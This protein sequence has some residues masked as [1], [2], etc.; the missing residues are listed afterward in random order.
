MRNKSSR[1]RRQARTIP[2]KGSDE[3]GNG[4]DA[5]VW[6]RCWNCGFICSTDRDS[7]GGPESGSGVIVQ[8]FAVPVHGAET[9]IPNSGIARLGGVLSQ[10]TLA[11]G[12]DDLG[13]TQPIEEHHMPVVSGGCPFCGTLD[14][15]GDYP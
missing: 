14:W 3:R 15:K 7:L 9:G 12:V 8:D 6:Y 11:L 5:G 4:L 13:N 2:L 10:V 1:I